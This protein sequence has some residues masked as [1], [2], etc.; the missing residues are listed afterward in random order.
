MSLYF[1]IEKMNNSDPK[2]ISGAGA[3]NDSWRND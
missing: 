3:A 2:H 1:L